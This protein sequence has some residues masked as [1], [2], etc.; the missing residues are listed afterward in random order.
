MKD[1]K[2]GNFDDF[3]FK[4]LK[5]LDMFERGL[6]IDTGMFKELGFNTSQVNTFM[7]KCEYR[8][9][10]LYEEHKSDCNRPGVDGKT[11]V[12]GMAKRHKILSLED[13]I[14]C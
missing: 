8:G 6:L 9:I 1:K 12:Y 4:E 3:S 5:A 2:E 14:L 11:I 13:E 10:L 7:N